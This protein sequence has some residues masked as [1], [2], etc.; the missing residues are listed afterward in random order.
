MSTTQQRTEHS[1]DATPPPVVTAQGRPLGF[2]RTVPRGLV[3]RASIGEVF[4][5]DAAVLGV[6]RYVVAAQ[7]PRG[8]ALYGDRNDEHYDP[9]IVVEACRQASIL[10]CHEFYGVPTDW[11]FVFRKVT[12]EV[13]EPEALRIGDAPGR[14]EIIAEFDRLRFDKVGRLKRAGVCYEARL[15]GLSICAG[16][17]RGAARRLS[18]CAELSGSLS[19]MPREQFARLRQEGRAA[20]SLE[21]PGVPVNR[22]VAPIAPERV[23]RLNRRN[24]VIA[25]PSHDT[26]GRLTYEVVVDTT[27][28]SLC[29]HQVDH[30]SGMLL[31][32]AC[33]Q[34]ALC[35][36]SEFDGKQ[37]PAVR[38]LPTYFEVA[39]QDFV[40]HELP[41][42]CRVTEIAERDGGDTV[43][44]AIEL[45][46]GEGVAIGT[47]RVQVMSCQ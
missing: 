16:L 25:E 22:A 21:G 34:A 30:V 39:F 32:E 37:I 15:D 1:Q 13:I 26:E 17:L 31:T 41:S 28:P 35:A 19:F 18:I 36:A 33:R 10:A 9:L 45:V 11:A 38:A 3:H 2:E 46:Q 4:V 40:E 5:T 43:D 7:L 29:D 23:G 12:V 42:Y 24:V 14:L 8:H 44:V 47:A 6:N 20:K 27:H